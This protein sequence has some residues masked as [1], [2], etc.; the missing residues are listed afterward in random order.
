MIR[1]NPTVQYLFNAMIKSIPNNGYIA[2]EDITLFPNGWI[3]LYDH[4][5][6]LEEKRQLG[7]TIRDK[8]LLIPSHRTI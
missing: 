8:I 4:Q 6:Q 3:N 1:K 2:M 7:D 5:H